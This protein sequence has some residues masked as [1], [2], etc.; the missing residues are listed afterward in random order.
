MRYFATEQIPVD[1]VVLG[2][3]TRELNPEHVQQMKQSFQRTMQLVP[4]TVA[5]DGRLIDGQHRL[6]AAKQLGW[7]AVNATIFTDVP[8]CV[9]AIH[10]E[11]NLHSENSMH[12]R[13][14][15]MK[16]YEDQLEPLPKRE[17]WVPATLA[18]AGCGTKFVQRNA[19]H[20]F[21]SSNCRVIAHRTTRAVE[22]LAD[23]VAVAQNACAGCGESL[24]GR[25]R[26]AKYC[27]TSCRTRVWKQEH[28]GS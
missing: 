17:R 14:E 8:E 26:R 18:C 27:S 24:A 7:E 23:A 5:D 2:D 9:G 19:R 10:L 25:T 12:R 22:K 16:F 13:Y 6:E 28:L 1:A 3:W 15:W 20:M 4:I 11:A 21:C